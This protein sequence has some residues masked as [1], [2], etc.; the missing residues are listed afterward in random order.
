M[1]LILL[2][3]QIL[4]RSCASCQHW[5][6]DDDHH[7]ILRLGQPI[8]R[9]PG[10]PTPCWKC[11]KKSPHAARGLERDLPE[12]ASALELYYRLR[13]T[14]GGCL[15]D[16]QRCDPLLARHMAIIDALVRQAERDQ[17]VR[18]IGGLLKNSRGA[19]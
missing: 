12:T 17:L 13:A 2:H 18:M 19:K 7:L 5:L 15:S 11:V 1:K 8:A 9:P 3:P 10:S 14:G 16:A 6:F 4:N